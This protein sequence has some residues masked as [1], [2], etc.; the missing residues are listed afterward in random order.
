MSGM[1]WWLPSWL[2]RDHAYRLELGSALEYDARREGRDPVVVSASSSAARDRV[3]SSL[4][5]LTGRVLSIAA[6]D[7]R[8]V[9][10]DQPLRLYERDNEG[11]T[12]LVPL[13]GGEALDLQ[14]PI[15]RGVATT[16]PAAMRWLTEIQGRTWTPIRHRELGTRLLRDMFVSPELVRTTRDGV[17]YFSPGGV[18]IRAGASLESVVVRPTLR[19]LS[20]LEQLRAALEPHGWT[21]EPSD[22]GI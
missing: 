22:K 21:S 7:W 2:R 16:D 10:P 11:R 9:L 8:E 20:V 17:G 6:A 19:P 3:A 18:L 12:E 5:E 15:P 13:Y 14:T 4:S 1:A